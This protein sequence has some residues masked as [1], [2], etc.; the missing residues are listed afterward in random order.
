MQIL[1]PFDPHSIAPVGRSIRVMVIG[2]A[3]R[4][5][6]LAERLANLGGAIDA[7][8]D[9]YTGL[10]AVIEDPAG[11]GLC[12]IECDA[13]GGL[14]LGRR[15]YALMGDAALRV[16]VILVSGE[17]KQQEF[18]QDRGKPVVLRGPASKLSMRMGFEHALRDRFPM[19]FI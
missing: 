9:L 1:R 8:Q 16:P 4:A 6:L 13:I 7:E 19:Q 2:V 3:S 5:A 18:P 14:A 10:E 12:V 17:C 15:A 11:Y